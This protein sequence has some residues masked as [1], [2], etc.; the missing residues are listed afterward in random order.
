MRKYLPIV[1][2]VILLVVIFN[3]IFASR[4]VQEPVPLA[5]PTLTPRP[6]TFEELNA[7]YGPCVRLPVI[8]YHHVQDMDAAKEKGQQNL[9]VST[10]TFTGQMQYL[11]DKGYVTLGTN[12]ITD[13]FDRGV[14]VPKRSI[15]LSFDDGYEDFY[16][17]ALPILRQ[18]GF[19]A[20]VALSTGLVGNPGYLSWDQVSQIAGA[21]I[22]IVSHGWSHANL[23]GADVSLVQREIVTADGQ[24]GERGYNANKVFVYPYGGYN[25]YTTN[26]LQS[27]GYT[28]S[29]TTVGGSI[30]CKKQRLILPRIRIGNTSLSAYGF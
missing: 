21:G 20:L 19:R 14:A 6:L 26:F 25:S 18:F 11:K 5:S 29:F 4:V 8:F 22:E 3:R 9:T 17:N 7:L 24:L 12:S 28:L 23:G 10:S 13:F 27:K 2:L 16:L 30:L 1:V 15:I